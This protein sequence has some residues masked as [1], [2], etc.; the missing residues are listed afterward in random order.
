M[1][2]ALQPALPRSSTAENAKCSRFFTREVDGLAQE[3]AGHCWMNPPYGREIGKWVRK[4]YDSAMDGSATL[5]CLL[6]A[7]TDTAWFQEYCA[8]GEIIFLRG[9]LRFSGKDPA[10]FPSVI[11]IFHA[12]LDPGGTMRC[13]DWR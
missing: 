6:P 7:R 8:A 2:D 3:W 5:V 11:A 4:A 12:H 13:E 1:T 9:R 10:P